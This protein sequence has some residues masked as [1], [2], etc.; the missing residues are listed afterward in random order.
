MTQRPTNDREISAPAGPANPRDAADDAMAAYALGERA[1]FARLYALISAELWG[2][3][4][5]RVHDRAAAEDLMQQTL[6]H[7]HRARGRYRPG[8][9]ARP[10]MYTIA[11]RLIIDRSRRRRPQVGLDTMEL[12]DPGP[13]PHEQIAAGELSSQLRSAYHQLPDRQKAALDLTRGAGLSQSEAAEV[14][15]T[16]RSAV[17]SLVHRALGTLETAREPEVHD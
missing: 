8:A 2:F 13:G 14:L 17:K 7:M 11:W 9:R 10:W 12:A 6:L 15:G 5:A 4:F 16:T 1:A 3:V